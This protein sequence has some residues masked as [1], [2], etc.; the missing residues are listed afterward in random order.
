MAEDVCQLDDD[1]PY[2]VFRDGHIFE[3]EEVEICLQGCMCEY[4]RNYTY[5]VRESFPQGDVILVRR[6]FLLLIFFLLSL[7]FWVK[8]LCGELNLI[9]ISALEFEDVFVF[10]AI[11]EE[12]FLE[13]VQGCGQVGGL[14]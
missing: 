6:R 7:V 14:Q 3:V 2:L 12:S 10:C 9:Q 1:E 5:L 13:D 8:E 4:L 11:V